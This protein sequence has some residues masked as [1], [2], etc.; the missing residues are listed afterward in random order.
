MTLLFILVLAFALRVW[1]VSFGLPALVHADEPIVVNHAMQYGLGSFHP[2]FFK[3]PP[4]A[5]Y[6]LFG[7]YGLFY[8]VLN[9]L[10]H[11]AST[12][13]FGRLFVQDPSAFYLLGR[14]TLGVLPGT[15]TV[16]FLYRWVRLIRPQVA[17]IAA[18]LLSVLFLHVR[19]SHFIY[20]DM[21]LVLLFV[22]TAHAIT[23]YGMTPNKKKA[24]VFGILL[25]AAVAMK[26]NGVFIVIPFIITHFLNRGSLK[27]S[28]LF[29]NLLIAALL[30]LI[31]FL[32]LNPYA[33]LDWR[34]FWQELTQQGEAQ[35]FTGL[36]HHLRYSLAGAG[37]W[38]LMLTAGL[39]I[40]WA[41]FKQDRL[42]YPWIIFIGSYYLVICFFGQHYD[43]YALP[44]IPF[45][46]FFSAYFIQAI[47]QKG[48]FGRL[49]A[50]ILILSVVAV[51][52]I[53]TIASDV[54]MSRP[55]IRITAGDW[56]K[57]ELPE[58]SRIALG[59]P[60][61]SP[62]FDRSLEQIAE[63]SLQAQEQGDTVMMKRL[64]WLAEKPAGKRFSLHYLSEDLAN[65]FSMNQPRIRYEPDELMTN[66]I[67]YVV[68]IDQNPSF[69]PAFRDWL[70]NHATLIKVFN[71][72]GDQRTYP[73]DTQPLTGQPFLWYELWL[74]NANG[75]PIRLY[76]LTN[77]E[78]RES[79]L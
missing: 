68:W 64:S 65:S 19:D 27:K 71:P 67:Q 47:G 15:L 57:K 16:F 4:L 55:D 58:G 18:F 60:R 56:M 77:K 62:P 36:T 63:I 30:S 40:A 61:F 51:S 29:F 69:Q 6:L 25:G 54:L 42:A 48:N 5:S 17:L 74:R 50:A 1:G 34:F 49:I 24:L 76:E 35:G 13:D 2:H 78:K 33:L 32:I 31:I 72:Y 28:D 53:K 12:E 66:D 9:L 14:L 3:I 10:G 73:I 22:L 8:L 44:L 46:I 7:V 38:P 52:L 41:L 70:E 37:G 11:I 20:A 79:T 39:G 45:V 21:S 75:L 59:E 43:R 23:C 26:Y